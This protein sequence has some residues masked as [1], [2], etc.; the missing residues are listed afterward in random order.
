LSGA[1]RWRTLQSMT[2]YRASAYRR[3]IQTLRDMGPAKL[4]PEE[5]AC[6]REAADSLLFCMEPD[7]DGAAQ[8]ALAA[9]AAL[10]DELI[11]AE[12]WTPERAQ[13]LLDDVWAC[14]PWG[15]LDV[16]IAA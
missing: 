10:T 16:S 8:L 4:W 5:Q 9:A 13:R 7:A 6:L 15:T 11:D 3:V 12:R 1:R 2:S 14:G